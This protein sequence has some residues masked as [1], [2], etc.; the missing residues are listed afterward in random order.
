MLPLPPSEAT[1]ARR[2]LPPAQ[3]TL[4]CRALSPAHSTLTQR[5]LPPALPGDPPSVPHTGHDI[6]GLDAGHIL[7]PSQSIFAGQPEDEPYV[8]YQE[9]DPDRHGDFEEPEPAPH[10]QSA[11]LFEY[12][13]DSL[14]PPS[15]HGEDAFDFRNP[16]HEA[17]E[18]ELMDIAYH[19]HIIRHSLSVQATT[20][21]RR[22][23][24]AAG[25]LKPCDHRTARLRF[26]SLTGITPVYYDC[27]PNI[28]ISYSMYPS[29]TQCPRCGTPRWRPDSQVPQERHV[30][31]PVTHRLR[32]WFSD[33]KR[34]LTLIAYRRHAEA[35]GEPRGAEARLVD[36]WN[37]LLFRQL[38]AKGLFSQ[39][40][41]VAFFFSTDGMKVF[42]TR[43]PFY[44]QPMILAC[45]NLPPWQR[46]R[47]SNKLTV[48]FIPGPKNPLEPDSFLYPIVREF[49]EGLAMGVK[50]WD[51]S[52]R[53]EFT[54]RAYICQI[55]ADMPGRQKLM[56][57]L[58]NRA[59]SYCE[60]CEIRGLHKDGITCPHLPP[61]DA[62]DSV[63]QRESAKHPERQLPYEWV[64][65]DSSPAPVRTD[66]R[67][68]EQAR[69]IVQTKDAGYAKRAG[70]KGEAILARLPSVIFPWS[71]PPDI[72]HL[73]F[74]NI[75]PGLMRHYMGTFFPDDTG[76]GDC[77]GDGDAA[78]Q[79]TQWGAGKRVGPALRGRPP[80]HP[81]V[82]RDREGLLVRTSPH[83]FQ[84]ND[85]PWNVAPREWLILS[86]DID[87]SNTTFPSAFGPHLINYAGHVGRMTAAQWRIWTFHLA[88]IYLRTRIP[89]HHYE[90]L[91]SLVQAVLIMN[92]RCVS[93]REIGEVG[94]RLDRFSRFYETTFYRQGWSRL[95]ACRPVF[96]Q[97]RHCAES[98]RWNGPMPH[99]AQW[100]M[101]RFCG[102]TARY[103]KS[104][105]MANANIAIRATHVEMENHLPYVIQLP[106][107]QEVRIEELGSR[108]ALIDQ[109]LEEEGAEFAA[110][111]AFQLRATRLQRMT[112]DEEV[113]FIPA[114]RRAFTP[115][116]E[117]G[118]STHLKLSDIYSDSHALDRHQLTLLSRWLAARGYGAMETFIRKWKSLTIIRRGEPWVSADTEVRVVG[119]HEMRANRS[120]RASI[121]TYTSPPD[122]MALGEVLFF[123]TVD[124]ESRDQSP[125]LHRDQSPERMY[126][127]FVRRLSTTRDGPLVRLAESFQAGTHMVIDCEDIEDLAGLIVCGRYMYVTG[128]L[129]C[130]NM[131]SST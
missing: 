1:L 63:R 128:R 42:K 65:Y 59:C 14:L 54:L 74:E 83:N 39:P 17:S 104:R 37:G 2:T 22:I 93:W 13:R 52:A 106:T 60:Y 30:I 89:N 116:P 97:I 16:R 98:L 29:L 10:T 92:S 35:L 73:I 4:T 64:D 123:L 110:V 124:I 27:C 20:E 112:R 44:T 34:A 45:M 66:T 72:M 105:S 114:A 117:P 131:T 47:D 103:A 24:A 88:P 80:K 38:K 67:M 21:G 53:R 61:L 109:S 46:F 121:I 57:T 41:D 19:S 107:Y 101:E 11:A 43:K 90:E 32:L 95:R 77:L 9:V 26:A 55:G 129:S 8:E 94:E 81:I 100:F 91:I 96:H 62:P 70:I 76:G 78:G 115:D 79:S 122:D 33:P 49:A 36:F 127:A 5:A 126:L 99:H 111:L 85:D 87:R 108:E 28:C 69:H 50:A 51:A 119:Q 71:F 118:S 125:E 15:Q 84:R 6:E 12:L 86:A 7:Q 68:R 48:G 75:M 23:H 40:T 120:R 25:G 82:P 102:T 3:P 56:A 18:Q 113:G 58:G 130:L 31:F